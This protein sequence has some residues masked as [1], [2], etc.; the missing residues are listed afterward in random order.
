MSARN[1]RRWEQWHIWLN[2]LRAWSQR[3]L[4]I[5]NRAWRCMTF[6]GLILSVLSESDFSDTLSAS[7]LELQI[8][9]LPS[10]HSLA[11]LLL[12]DLCCLGDFWKIW[13]LKGLIYTWHK[14]KGSNIILTAFM[15]TIIFNN[16]FIH[17]ERDGY[18]CLK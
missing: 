10:R 9:W 14:A 3:N 13:L 4:V 7:S 1:S 15:N 18:S 2:L 8:R 17:L 16:V 5:W 12:I 11:L 6:I